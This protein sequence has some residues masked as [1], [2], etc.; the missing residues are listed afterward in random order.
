MNKKIYFKIRIL[1]LI[2]LFINCTQSKSPSFPKSLEQLCLIHLLKGQEAIAEVNR[3]HGKEIHVK[4][5]WVAYY[6][7]NGHEAT[8]WIS[9][10]FNPKEAKS[11]TE[12][13][14]EKIR[15][16][17]KSPFSHFKLTKQKNLTIYTFW[18]LGKKHAVF[19]KKTMVYWITTTPDVFNKVLNYYVN[20]FSPTSFKWKRYFSNSNRIVSNSVS[21]IP[22]FT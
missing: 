13:M 3:L 18:G 11:Q 2:L 9:E 14:M 4:N 20:N 22:F 19:Y 21:F 7:G 12:I 15:K 16:N 6:R 1:W 5:A 10:A 17:I 8:I